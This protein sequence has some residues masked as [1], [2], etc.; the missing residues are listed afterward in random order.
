VTEKRQSI[1]LVDDSNFSLSQL[2]AALKDNFDIV[3]AK[4]GAEGLVML[5]KQPVDLIITDL[6]MPQISGLAFIGQVKRRDPDMKTIV[7]SA[8]VQ[9]ATKK[10]ARTI[11]AA[12]FLGKP[13]DPDEVLSVV[14]LVLAHDVAPRDIPIAPKYTDAFTEIF[15]IGV[16]KAADSLSKL[17]FD[18]VRL[19]VP[20]LEILTPAQLTEQVQE[21][22]TDDIACIRQEFRGTASGSAYLLLSAASGINLVNALVRQNKQEKQPLSD[23]DREMLVE[24]GNILINALVGTLANTLDIDFDFGQAVCQVM[25]S[26]DVNDELELGDSQY[27]LYVETLFVVPGRQIGGNL[28]ILLGADGMNSITRRMEEIM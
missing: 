27:V 19:S 4:N 12:A 23:A 22:F 5:E 15:N 8:D 1:L 3:K 11:G 26:D 20:Q 18:T 7:C 16:G 17:V 6:L 14:N 9:E 21:K 24:V 10:K 28:A 25:R 13:I 2:E